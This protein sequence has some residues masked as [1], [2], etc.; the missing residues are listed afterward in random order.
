MG[1]DIKL[2]KTVHIFGS[3]KN[4]TASARLGDEVREALTLT[5]KGDAV[6]ALALGFLSS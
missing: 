1:A 6:F 2:I 5:N 4:I 3:N